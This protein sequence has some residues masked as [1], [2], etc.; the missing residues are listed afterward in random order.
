MPDMTGPELIKERNAH[1]FKHHPPA[2]VDVTNR[3]AAAR[4]ALLE[5]ANLLADVVPAGREQ[6]LALTKLEE[7]MMWA[8]A[9][10]ARVMA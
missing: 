9:G 1:N 8:N 2:S 10:V 5:A 4:E 6:S 3:H 7:A